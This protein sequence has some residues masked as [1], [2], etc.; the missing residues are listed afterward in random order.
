MLIPVA[1]LVALVIA[2]AAYYLLRPNPTQ[3]MRH[4][5]T[6]YVLEV[7]PAQHRITVRNVDVPNVM[8]S[9]VMDYRVDDAAGL[10][11]VKAGDEISATMVMEAGRYSL[12]DIKVTGKR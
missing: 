7:T 9:M 10:A 12:E 4:S 2:I 1:I 5:M 8:E 3:S 6:G 11:N